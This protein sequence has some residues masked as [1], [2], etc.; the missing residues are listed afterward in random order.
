MYVSTNGGQ[1][2]QS[3]AA[4]PTT[5]TWKAVA[6]AR[7]G[8]RLVAVEAGGSVW[9][10]FNGVWTAQAAAGVR[11]WSAVDLSQNGRTIVAGVAGE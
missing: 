10:Y 8:S 2:W 5:G 9:T 1:T 6:P 7:D 11:P 3:Q 4:L